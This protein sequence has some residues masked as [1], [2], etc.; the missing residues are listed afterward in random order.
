M[1]EN[2]MT[3]LKR[4]QDEAAV[5]ITELEQ[6]STALRDRISD[7]EKEAGQNES[8]AHLWSAWGRLLALPT[9]GLSSVFC[10]AEAQIRRSESVRASAMAVAE[11]ANKD[12]AMR[13]ALI[14]N[15]ILIPSIKES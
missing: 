6:L 9:F 14:T 13:A 5:S 7:L 11:T 8:A 3:S 15:E 4:R 10:E 1:H 12:I 2:L